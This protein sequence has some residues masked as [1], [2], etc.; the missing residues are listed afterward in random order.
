MN[1]SEPAT[2]RTYDF[3]SR[4]YDL[5][6]GPLLRHHQGRAV[7]QLH[8]RPGDRVLD[9]GVGTGISLIH[10]PKFVQVVGMD[11]SGGMLTI[12]ARKCREQR[13][14]N[15][16]LVRADAM[17]PPFAPNCFD[18]V[19]VTHTV[20]VVS[21]PH[22]L[23]IWASELVKPGGRIVLVNHF[24]SNHPVFAW[25]ERVLNPMFVKLGWRSDLRLDELLEGLDLRV[26][27]HF[28]PHLT[29]LWQIVVLNNQ[30]PRRAGGQPAEAAG[31]GHACVVGT[32]TAKVEK[33]GIFI[34]S[35]PTRSRFHA[36]QVEH[37]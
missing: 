32:L 12:A 19:I 8:L 3:W 17:L 24:Q 10:Y 15:C 6:L 26:E 31:L 34:K 21:N 37:R 28:K 1:M 22:R 30:Q 23:L 35:G 16:H 7:A 5:T 20:S 13:L 36:I 27:Y 14:D 29:D 25:F 33:S 2:S 4:F 18:H 11:L 9:I